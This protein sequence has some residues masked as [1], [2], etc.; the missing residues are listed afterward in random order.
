MYAYPNRRLPP[1][2]Y[3]VAT[4]VSDA[5]GVDANNAS[6]M[7]WPVGGLRSGTPHS[8][9]DSPSVAHEVTFRG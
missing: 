2:Q 5:V 9:A 8:T 4:S 3:N 1:R 6:T 7:S